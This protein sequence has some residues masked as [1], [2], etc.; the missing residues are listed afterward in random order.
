MEEGEGRREKEAWQ[1]LPGGEE[2]GGALLS[3]EQKSPTRC[4]CFV[5]PA[6]GSCKRAVVEHDNGEAIRRISGGF[7]I[8][9]DSTKACD[10]KALGLE[11]KKLGSRDNEGSPGQTRGGEKTHSFPGKGTKME[12]PSL[13]LEQRQ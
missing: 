8:K 5:V 11:A 6:R 2:R 3:T 4:G 9:G 13:A 1:T 12:A 7:V 10:N